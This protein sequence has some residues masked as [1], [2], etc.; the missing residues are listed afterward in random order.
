LYRTKSSGVAELCSP[1]LNVSCADQRH[2]SLQQILQGG[3]QLAFGIDKGNQ[4]GCFQEF[5][6][7]ADSSTLLGRLPTSHEIAN[8]AAF[9]A[10]DRASAITGT[11]VS[12]TCGSRVE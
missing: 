9:M 7:V 4:H 3:A 5:L 1:L 12:V 10:S 6:A 8:V 2:V 11:F